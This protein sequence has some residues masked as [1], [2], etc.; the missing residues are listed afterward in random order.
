M[1][2]LLATWN[3]LPEN[4]REC[5]SFFVFKRRLEQILYMVYYF[6]IYGLLFFIIL[7]IMAA[8]CVSWRMTLAIFCLSVTR[9]GS[10]ALLT[11]F[12]V[13]IY[14]DCIELFNIVMW[15]Q[16]IIFLYTALILI[17][18]F[19]FYLRDLIFFRKIKLRD[20]NV[21]YMFIWIYF[22]CSSLYK[23]LDFNLLPYK[24]NV[25]FIPCVWFISNKDYYY[26]FVSIIE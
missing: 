5:G 3:Q 21:M 20:L 10:G 1:L 25:L 13:K 4:L 17:L 16:L 26:K 7:F 14:V 8:S 6:Y 24:K 19:L 23:G 11:M 22:F 2:G 9:L 12:V 15:L 18:D